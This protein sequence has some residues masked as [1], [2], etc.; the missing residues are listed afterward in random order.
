VIANPPILSALKYGSIASTSLNS[1]PLLEVSGRY[2]VKM[3]RMEVFPIGMAYAR[4]YEQATGITEMARRVI[5]KL[6]TDEIID[7]VG[8]GSPLERF[9]DDI[10]KEPIRFKSGVVHL[11]RGPGLGVELDEKKLR[12]FALPISIE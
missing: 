5:V 6:Y 1:Y 10:V 11:P 12:K 4:P 8:Y 2:S 9:E 7:S 3:T